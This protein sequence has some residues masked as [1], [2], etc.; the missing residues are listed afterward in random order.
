MSDKPIGMLVT[1]FVI[2][3]IC[4]VCVLGPAF[5]FSWLG[6]LFV[7]I[8]PVLAT[9]LAIVAAIVVF[10]LVKRR[11]AHGEKRRL[12]APTLERGN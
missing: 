10:G 1:A 9:A 4:S 11:K 5:L 8:N 12:H 3:P 7:G 2:A 6:G